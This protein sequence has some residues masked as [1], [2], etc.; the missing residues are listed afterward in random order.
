MSLD[1]T[2][3]FSR[4]LPAVANT[5]VPTGCQYRRS[6]TACPTM[7]EH[8]FWEFFTVN[9][10]NANTRRA[11]FKAVETFAAW[12]ADRGLHN[13]AAVTPMHVA[14][15]VEQLGRTHCK[16]H[17]EAAPRRHPHALRLAGHR[18]GRRCQLIRPMPCGDRSIASRRARLPCST[19]TKCAI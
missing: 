3:A 9:I 7:A 2:A 19:P 15:Y 1:Q 8:R 16:A 11:Y 5:A 14:A 12:C 18:P 4:T 17:G 13:L 6:S 10:R